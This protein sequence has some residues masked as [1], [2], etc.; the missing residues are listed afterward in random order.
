MSHSAILLVALALLAHLVADFVFQT[1]AI[2]EAKA[3]PGRQAWR[4]L[5]THAG[6]VAICLLPFVL[7]YG[8]RGF[9]YLVIVAVAHGLIDRVKVVLNQRAVV[10]ARPPAAPRPA[11]PAAGP[12]A[13][14]V[15]VAADAPDAADA[16]GDRAWTPL[17]AVLFIA[18]QAAHLVV[19]LVGASALLFNQ[20]TLTAWN[21][22]INGVL[23]HLLPAIDPV[24]ALTVLVVLVDLV[25]INI[26]GGFFLVGTLL[27]PRGFAAGSAPGPERVGAS[28]G[29]LERLIVCVL[30]LAGQ[31]AAIGFVIAAKTLARF[32]QLDDR[33][34]AEYYLVGTL[35]S[36]TL[37]LSTSIVAEAAISA[38]TR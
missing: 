36:V 28:I 10:R 16:P 2:A 37:A 22:A 8:A 38:A 9:G 4:G 6:I 35:A 31:A 12:A 14:D 18:D 34:F 25:I 17:P 1:D 11:E 24:A 29:I 30:V 20:P 32:R 7:A 23:T 15:P 26:R 19:L 3:A 13:A 27:A 5:A 33:H 21:D